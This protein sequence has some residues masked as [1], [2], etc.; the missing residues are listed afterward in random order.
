MEKDLYIT[1]NGTIG[2]GKTTLA[3]IIRKALED[4]GFETITE[5]EDSFVGKDNLN[6]K[7]K[8]VKE[9]FPIIKIKQFNI[10]NL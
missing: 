3:S 8:S 10:M 6:K 5:G 1:I 9:K 2:A 4:N 7:I